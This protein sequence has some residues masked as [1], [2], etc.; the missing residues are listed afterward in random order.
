MQ[1]NQKDILFAQDVSNMIDA[2]VLLRD[3]T[4]QDVDDLAEA[5][6]KYN[7]VCAFTWPAYTQLIGEKLRGAG[8][9]F[10]GAVSYPSGQEPTAIKVVQTEYFLGLGVSEVDMVMNLGWLKS[11]RFN[12]VTADIRSVKKACGAIPLKVII[13]A[14]MLSD[15]QIVDACKCV[16]D[17]GA[18]Y[19]KSGT[20]F[21]TEPTTLHH[22]ELMKNTV[23]D[24]IKLKVAG[25]VRS[26]DTLIRMYKMGT[27]R[28]GI[29]L[30]SAISIMQDA[31][32]HT[33]GID[34]RK[35]E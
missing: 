12:E 11:K 24:R 30:A 33:D 29:G 3:A 26:L 15:E 21:C 9:G 1:K 16:L 28:F 7:F 32:A 6:K 13:E 18:D 17:G 31:I 22:V 34:L 25:G 5:C 14:M 8:T 10:G 35:A 19:V 27:V 23:G 20:G 4:Y 2:S